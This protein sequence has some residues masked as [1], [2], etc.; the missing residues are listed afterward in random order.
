M[1][2]DNPRMW[3]GRSQL[4]GDTIAALPIARYFKKKFPN[5]HLIWPIAKKCS[6]GAALYFNCP[7]IDEIYITDGQEG[8]TSDRDFAK[9][10]SC[11]IISNVNPQHPAGPYWP[12]ERDIYEETWLMIGLPQSEWNNL[13]EEEQS[14]VLEKWF[15]LPA[16]KFEGKTIG[17]WCQAGY[18]EGKITERNPSKEYWEKLVF[19]LIEE[20]Y[21]V[22]QFGS[23]KD[24]N[25][26]DE[27][28]KKSLISSSFIR[29]NSLSF[30]DQ[31]R[32]S[33]TTDLTIGTDSGSSLILAA[34]QHPQISLLRMFQE[35]GHVKNPAAYG[36]RN[37]NN[38]SFVALGKSHDEINQELV[39]EK[40]H[41]FTA[42]RPLASV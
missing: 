28:D 24:W 29:M 8:V 13:T 15:N 36:P 20:G 35:Y 14:P 7:Y 33:L 2:K 25:L 40:I 30:I 27:S 6:Q 26:F 9:M 23:E 34:Y 5:G 39:F 38:F 22:L 19:R 21:K 10:N 4:L 18:A 17:I 16:K 1:Q 12:N 37:K 11:D 31:I 32:Y 41:E 3:I 42:K